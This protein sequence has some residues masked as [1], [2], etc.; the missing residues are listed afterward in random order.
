MRTVSPASRLRH[1]NVA[2]GPE[3]FDVTVLGPDESSTVVL[4]GVGAGGN[5]ERHLPLMESL[6]ARGFTVIA[7][8]FSRIVP[9]H[10]ADADLLLRGRRLKLALDAVAPNARRVAGVGH[11]IG[12][13]T[14]LPLAGAHMWTQSRHR[15]EFELIP[16]LSRLVMMT[17]PTLFFQPPGALDAVRTPILLLA[18]GKDDV[19]PPAQQEF[20][21]TAIGSRAAVLLRVEETAGHFSFMN[22]LPPGVTD[23]M[24]DREAFLVRLASEIC[25]FVE[26]S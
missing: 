23:A 25:S 11:S 3:S 22:V 18:G 2:D 17:P 5:P 12:A 15:L 16:T 1:D 20:L 8:H 26:Q 14:L 6:A 21:K 24:P 19:T 10:V 4:F 13:T 9:P 7:P